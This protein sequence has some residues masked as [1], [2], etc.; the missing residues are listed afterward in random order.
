MLKVLSFEDLIHEG[1]TNVFIVSTVFKFT[2]LIKIC[3][4]PCYIYVFGYLILSCCMQGGYR[5]MILVE[6]LR[7][8]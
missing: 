3:Y 6:K 7:G 1:V 4:A 8:L 2:N 5:F